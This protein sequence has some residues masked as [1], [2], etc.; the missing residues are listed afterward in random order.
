MY[1]DMIICSAYGNV[2]FSTGYSCARKLKP[3]PPAKTPGMD[4]L[5]DGVTGKVDSHSYHVHWKT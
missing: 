1:N 3:T 5:E 4:L 2:G